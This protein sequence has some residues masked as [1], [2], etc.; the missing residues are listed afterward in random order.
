M[1]DAQRVEIGFEGGQVISARLGEDAL[2][3]LRSRLEPGRGLAR[4]RDRGRRAGGRPRQDRLPAD[5]LRRAPGRVLQRG[6]MRR[7]LLARRAGRPRRRRSGG[8]STPRPAP[9][10]SV[11]GSRPRTR[12][13][14]ASGCARCCGPR[15]GERILEIGPGTGYYTLDIAEWVGADGKVEIFDLQQEMLD[16]TMRR[17]AERGLANVVPDPGR[18]HLAPLRGRLDRRGRAGHGA[19]RDPRPRRGSARDPAGPAAGRPAGRRRAVRRPSLPG[20]RRPPRALRGGRAVPRGALGK[21]PRATS[22]A[23]PP[24]PPAAMNRAPGGSPICETEDRSK[25]LG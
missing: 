17:A 16:H 8:A 4:P 24:R 3:D 13:S 11:S 18:C 14:P 7:L 19:R 20:L 6:L 9:T 1:A 21:P 15:A 25:E 23:S 5:R 12:S 22:P 2:S 10:A